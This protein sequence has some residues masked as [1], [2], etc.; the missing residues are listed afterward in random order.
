MHKTRRRAVVARILSCIECVIPRG[1][2][3]AAA[4][5]LVSAG[6]INLIAIKFAVLRSDGRSGDAAESH[7][8]QGEAMA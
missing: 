2:S 1:Q 6:K 7:F 3:V 4:E 8:A 5:L